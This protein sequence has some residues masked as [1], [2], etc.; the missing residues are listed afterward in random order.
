MHL[1]SFRLLAV[2]A[3]FAAGPT[4]CSSCKKPAPLEVDAAAPAVS[5]APA[6]DAEAPKV[7]EAVDAAAPAIT[8]TATPAAAGDAGG[9]A[10]PTSGPFAGSYKCMNGLNVSQNGTHVSGSSKNSTGNV[11]TYS[12]TVAGDTCSGTETYVSMIKGVP[13]PGKPTPFTF[14]LQSGGAGL[15]YKNAG[16]VTTINC[17]RN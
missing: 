15:T 10:A 17:K 11:S 5:A 7:E 6:S 1:G 13:K 4:A 3:V 14:S 16:A 8:A 12:C 9:K 2:V